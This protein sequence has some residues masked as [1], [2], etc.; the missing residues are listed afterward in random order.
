M[1]RHVGGRACSEDRVCNTAAAIPPS[2][3]HAHAH[4]T[5]PTLAKPFKPTSYCGLHR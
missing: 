2:T 4:T 3:R 1:G 5:L